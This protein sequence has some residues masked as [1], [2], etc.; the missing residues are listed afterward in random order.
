MRA[1]SKSARMSPRLGLERLISAITACL[2]AAIFARSAFSKPR[3]GGISR[4]RRSRFAGAMR[5]FDSSTSRRLL[6]RMRARTS[7]ISPRLGEA[8]RELHQVLELRARR[9]ARERIAGERHAVPE[10]P[11][12]APGRTRPG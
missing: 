5:R 1:G 2:P 8:A 10:A 12:H 7:D 4:A 9:S 3:G 6:A 11:P